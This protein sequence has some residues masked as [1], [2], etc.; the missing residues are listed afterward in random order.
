MN[1]NQISL[2]KETKKLLKK[3]DLI[4]NH[5]LGQNFLID[6]AKRNQII[7]F[8]NINS[9]DTILEIGP[10]IGTLTLKMAKKAKKVICIEKD[11]KVLN[12]LNKR[13][14]DNSIDN[15]EII[16]DDALKVDFPRFD[17]VISNLPYQI[18][19]PITF[20][21]LNYP[22]K[23][24]VLM[25]QKEFAYRMLSNV[26]E[27]NYS[28]LSA[29]LHFKVDIELLTKVP[30]ECFMPKPKIDS[31][32]VKL[33]PNNKIKDKELFKNYEKVCKALFQHKN[34]KA[35]NSII[36]SRHELG[37][38]DKKELK[39]DIKNLNSENL[40]KL[41]EKRVISLSP[42]EILEITKLLSDIL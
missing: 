16:N 30:A 3:Y 1:N 37:Y 21:L 19:S 14:E 24:G 28:R 39:T 27:R 32:V 13:I 33:T 36:N 9:N 31:A 15:I 35:E 4:L 12:I 23:F 38:T 18:S 25:Y 22:F 17:K 7:D 29:M 11:K 8:G 2:A 26:G 34:K 10:G 6:D 20:K 41:L 5:N 42:E 40:D